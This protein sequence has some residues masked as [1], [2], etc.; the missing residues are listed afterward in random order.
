MIKKGATRTVFLI[1]KYAIKTPT[2]CYGHDHFLN[3]CYGNWL[4]RKYF[5]SWMTYKSNVKVAPSLFCS[6][7]GLIQIQIRCEPMIEN[8]TYEQID[9]F[10]PLCGSD[11]KKENFG[12]YK[13]EL[14][15]LDYV[16]QP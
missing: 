9:F 11:F 8:L 4:E 3:G 5:K 16:Y 13:E 14:V 6:W 7:F 12:W 1:G 15:C 10:K 2:L